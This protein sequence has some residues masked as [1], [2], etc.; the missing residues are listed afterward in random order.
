L[1]EAQTPAS[2]LILI[3]NLQTLLRLHHVTWHAQEACFNVCV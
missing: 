2:V 3:D 1:S